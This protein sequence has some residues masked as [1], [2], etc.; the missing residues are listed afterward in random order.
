[1]GFYNSGMFKNYVRNQILIMLI[2]HNRDKEPT[3]KFCRKSFA[4]IFNP[5][6]QQKGV[7]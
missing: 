4:W 2:T 5:G 6:V 3:L 7:F 1:M